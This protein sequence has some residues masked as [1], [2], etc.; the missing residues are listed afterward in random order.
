MR[1]LDLGSGINPFRP[2]DFDWSH[3]DA[4]VRMPHVEHVIDVFAPLPF[5]DATYDVLRAVDIAEHVS[6]RRTHEVLAEWARVLAPG[7]SLF[8]QV[9]SAGTIMEWY[10]ARD[11][12]LL[13][14]GPGVPKT[15]LGGAMWRLLGGLDDGHY[16][17]TG[18]DPTL[19]LHMAMFDEESLRQAVE[20]A[21]FAV[22]SIA[23]NAH[24]NLQATA[25][26]K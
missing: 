2:D 25:R 22:E 18:G 19:N 6:Y 10:A 13:H 14:V 21:G 20:R 15:F 4:D 16:T 5:E 11:E 23:E 3:A 12:R 8:I 17:E 24:P 26:R 7:G 9:P 1:G